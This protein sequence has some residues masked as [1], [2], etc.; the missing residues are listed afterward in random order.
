MSSAIFPDGFEWDPRKALAN[1]A[2]HGVDFVAAARI[3]DGPVLQRWDR[4]QDYGEERIIAVGEVE[5]VRL[6]LVYVYRGEARRIISA[7]LARR[8]ERAAWQAFVQAKGRAQG[9]G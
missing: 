5:G 9:A 7:R 3:F 1:Q 4:R 2:K 6:A 8:D